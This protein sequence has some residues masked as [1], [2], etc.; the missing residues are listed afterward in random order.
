MAKFSGHSGRW[1]SIGFLVDF[2]FYMAVLGVGSGSIGLVA[3]LR[4]KWLDSQPVR[5]NMGR[6]WIAVMHFVMFRKVVA[7]VWRGIYRVCGPGSSRFAFPGYRSRPKRCV[8]KSYADSLW[9]NLGKC[10]L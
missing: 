1:G 7:A 8:T 9:Y 5:L 6:I 2:E 3:P 10:L 4:F